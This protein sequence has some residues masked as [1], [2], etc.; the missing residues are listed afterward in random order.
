MRALFKF[1]ESVIEDAIGKVDYWIP[2]YGRN[3]LM[4]MVHV[5]LDGTK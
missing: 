3:V 5:H 4:M 2:M 1:S